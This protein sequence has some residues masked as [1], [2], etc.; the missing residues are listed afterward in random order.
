MPW[1]PNQHLGLGK[2]LRYVGGWTDINP[3]YCRLQMTHKQ[4]NHP[5]Y[6]TVEY[7]WACASAYSDS[8]RQFHHIYIYTYPIGIIEMELLL[9]LK[10]YV[11]IYIFK[12]IYIYNIIY[13]IYYIHIYIYHS[14]TH[15]KIL[16]LKLSLQYSWNWQQCPSCVWFRRCLI[17]GDDGS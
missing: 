8:N 10:S 2:K 9:S 6:E 11:Y 14:M 12:C 7:V 15:T 17:V 1:Y 5:G 3:S 16:Q 4:V 13:I